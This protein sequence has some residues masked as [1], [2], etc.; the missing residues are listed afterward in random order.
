MHQL[1]ATAMTISQPGI[2]LC[3][4]SVALH[5]WQRDF[6]GCMKD[7]PGLFNIQVSSEHTTFLCIARD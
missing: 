7:F 4:E 6:Q 5:S 2:Q 3:V 1:A